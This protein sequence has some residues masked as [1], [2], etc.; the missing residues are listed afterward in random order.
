MSDGDFKRAISCLRSTKCVGP[1]ESPNFII[2]GSLSRHI[3]NLGLLIGRFPLLWKQT[4][5]VPIFKKGSSAV[6]TNYRP[7]SILNNFSKIFLKYCTRSPFLQFKI[8]VSP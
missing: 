8:Y 4:A 6:V 2:N 7:I 5:V 3:Y 1:D